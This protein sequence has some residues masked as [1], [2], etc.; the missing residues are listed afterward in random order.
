MIVLMRKPVMTNHDCA[1][2][3]Q[4]MAQYIRNRL[5]NT[6]VIAKIGYTLEVRNA[7]PDKMN[8]EYLERSFSFFP[9]CSVWT[10]LR[11]TARCL[12]VKQ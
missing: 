3:S 2:H 1:I 11:P 10:P 8:G 12:Q 7:A 5:R 9:S 6:Y 4:S